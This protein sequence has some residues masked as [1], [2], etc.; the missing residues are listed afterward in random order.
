MSSPILY[1]TAQDVQIWLMDFTD[2]RN[3]LTADPTV[4]NA[5]VFIS[6]DGGAFTAR[7][8]AG[9]LTF[10]A[11][12]MI[13]IA[14]DATDT[15][16][17]DLVV[18]IVDGGS[19][20]FEDNSRY[21]HTEGNSAAKFYKAEQATVADTNTKISIPNDYKADVSNLAL[22]A[23]LTTTQ[24]TVND[25][26]TK[27]SIP[28]DYKADVSLLALQTTLLATQSTVV[29]TNTKISIPANYMADVSSLALQSTLLATQTIVNG[30]ET[31]IG[32]IQNLG[33]G[34]TMGDNNFDIFNAAGGGGG[35]LTN[36]EAEQLLRIYAFCI[37]DFKSDDTLAGTSKYEYGLPG[38]A[39]GTLFTHLLVDG[40]PNITTRTV[41]IVP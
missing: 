26:N 33:T 3:Y 39:P 30:I 28:N 38:Q 35:G 22:E 16:C 14:L 34:A 8:A 2:T 24:S 7:N 20:V 9:T 40:A 15:T 12:G 4:L 41:K 10:L 37:G 19:K 17:K 1:A 5:E 36:D 18:A 25:T 6:K 32:T 13:K 21:F 29:D 23:T 11:L 27:I 31:S